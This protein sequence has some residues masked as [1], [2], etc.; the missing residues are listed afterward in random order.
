MSLSSVELNVGIICSCLPI[1]PALYRA[2]K[3]RCVLFYSSMRSIVR[4]STTK[5]SIAGSKIAQDANMGN[6]YDNPFT[7][8]KMNESRRQMV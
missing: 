1:M 6:R 8:D 4:G 3:P 2:Y 5:S 7:L